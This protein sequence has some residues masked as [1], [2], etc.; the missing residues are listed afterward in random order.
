MRLPKSFGLVFTL[1]MLAASANISA[2]AQ[3]RTAT[4]IQHLVVIFQEN[5]S[6]DHYFG[7]YPKAQN[8]PGETKFVA[9]PNTPVVNNLATPLDVNHNFAPLA[10]IDLLNNNPNADQNNPLNP[11]PPVTKAQQERRRCIEPLPTVAVASADRR[12]G[13]Q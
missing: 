7:T 1:T 13:P 8:N 9:K 5:V 6:F 10:G 2:I 12:S 11:I 4:P 3:D